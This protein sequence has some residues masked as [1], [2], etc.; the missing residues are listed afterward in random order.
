M[1]QGARTAALNL[2]LNIFNNK[3]APMEINQELKDIGK[4]KEDGFR[5]TTSKHL[6]AF[7]NT[8]ENT[9]KLIVL[10]RPTPSPI[11]KKGTTLEE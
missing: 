4:L 9:N 11:L 6:L 1:P 2:G 5:N 10:Y 3:V 7:V 8:L